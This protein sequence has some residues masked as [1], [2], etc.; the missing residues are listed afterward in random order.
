M[1]ASRQ[2]LMAV[3]FVAGVVLVMA[4]AVRVAPIRSFVFGTRT[5]QGTEDEVRTL[6]E[7]G[8]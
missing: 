2:A 5:N 3:A 6:T 4:A 1:T 8:I 7:A